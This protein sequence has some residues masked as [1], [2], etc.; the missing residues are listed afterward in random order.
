MESDFNLANNARRLSTCL[1]VANADLLAR[2]Y[3][4]KDYDPSPYKRNHGVFGEL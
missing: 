1:L 2:L 4:G 3:N